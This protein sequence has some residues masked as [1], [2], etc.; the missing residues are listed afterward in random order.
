[1]A[2][3]HSGRVQITTDMVHDR[4]LEE[5]S[6]LVKVLTLLERAGRLE[7]VYAL[8]DRLDGLVSFLPE[9][10][11]KAQAVA[12]VAASRA[13]AL[14][15]Q[16]RLDEAVVDFD[17]SIALT[18][19]AEQHLDSYRSLLEKGLYLS[20]ALRW[21]EALAALRAAEELDRRFD[22]EPSAE[23]RYRVQISIVSALVALD[24]PGDVIAQIG[25]ALAWIPFTACTALGGLL[26]QLGNYRLFLDMHDEALE[27]YRRGIAVCEE[28]QDSSMRVRLLGSAAIGSDL[29]WQVTGDQEAA[30]LSIRFGTQAVH[31]FVEIGDLREA[32][33]QVRRL[34]RALQAQDRAAEAMQAC[35]LGADLAVRIGS[36]PDAFALTAHA[37]FLASTR[38]R[39]HALAATLYQ[40][41]L[42]WG[43]GVPPTDRQRVVAALATLFYAAGDLATTARYLKESC[44][45]L[46]QVGAAVEAA[47]EREVLR[48]VTAEMTGSHEAA[49][50][51]EDG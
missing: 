38:L 48:R 40:Q 49:R 20:D 5:A 43:A 19:E 45:L 32:I 17:R 28:C 41:A 36:E 9:G 12:A 33:D 46:T 39:D 6:G 37:G 16:G 2:D 21:A 1:V 18:K 42:R 8:V 15:K 51:V 50:P 13:A 31:G 26:L 22:I 4:L 35:H 44:Q 34:V 14:A 25:N 29:K 7:D 11:T 23:Q 30:E 3:D 27:A 10:E 47:Q 24:R